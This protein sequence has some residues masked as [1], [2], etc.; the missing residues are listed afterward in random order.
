MILFTFLNPGDIFKYKDCIYKK[1]EDNPDKYTK[2][3]FNSIVMPHKIL[4][5]EDR[6][7]YIPNDS[8]VEIDEDDSEDY[9][10]NDDWE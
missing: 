9:R 10:F 3:L 7:D 5:S 6:W 4:Q 2:E 1:T 8:L